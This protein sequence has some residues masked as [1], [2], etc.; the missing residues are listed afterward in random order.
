MYGEIT[1]IKDH[2][3]PGPALSAE[4]EE[5][6]RL[7]V[8]DSLRLGMA[9]NQRRHLVD[10]GTYLE[11]FNINVER[12]KDGIPSKDSCRFYSTIKLLSS[13]NILICMTFLN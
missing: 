3:G 11:T 6:I 8:R 10:I 7:W 12:F 1:T 9:R 5:K 4:L 13:F 2:R